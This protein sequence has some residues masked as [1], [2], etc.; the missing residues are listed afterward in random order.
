MEKLQGP[1]GPRG[2]PGLV[3]SYESQGREGVVDGTR[4]GPRW[5]DCPHPRSAGPGFLLALSLLLFSLWSGCHQWEGHTEPASSA[6]GLP[7]GR[8]T[9]NCPS[10]SPALGLTPGWHSGPRVL[11]GSWS[12]K[13]VL[14]L[15]VTSTGRDRPCLPCSPCGPEQGSSKA[16]GTL[17]LLHT[18]VIVPPAGTE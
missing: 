2:G 10:M 9:W 16:A 15:T 14:N 18:P 7:C 13:C 17:P 6:L 12:W 3:L 8:P 4:L 5:Q 1:S 11:N